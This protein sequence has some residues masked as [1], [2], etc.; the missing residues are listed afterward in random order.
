[1]PYALVAH[2]A[3]LADGLTQPLAGDAL[4]DGS[5]PAAKVGFTYAGSASKGGPADVA[6]G[7][8]CTGCVTVSMLNIDDNIDMQG[9]GLQADTVIAGAFVGD[10]SALTGITMPQGV[11]A[12]GEAVVEIGADG[13]VVCA[14]AVSPEALP[15]DGLDE[16]SNG[17][18]ANQFVDTA[19]SAGA[20]A[21]KDNNPTG[22]ASEIVFPD[23]GIAQKLTVSV[24][25][26]NSDLLGLKVTLFDPDN[27]AYLLWDKGG[28]GASLQATYPEP[29]PTLSGD[30]TTWVGK[31][32]KGAWRLQV[33][34]TAPGAGPTDGA[35]NSWQVAIETLSN[36]KVASKGVFI[37]E[38]GLK[39]QTAD[40]AGQH[41]F[42]CDATS[43]G[44]MY[45]NTADAIVYV[46]DGAAMVPLSGN[47]PGGLPAFA[48]CKALKTARPYAPTGAYLLD[49]DG[50]N[51][52]MQPFEAFCEMDTDGGG[53]TLV[54]KVVALEH[55][56]DGGVLDSNDT[57][58]WKDKQYLGSI[59]DLRYENALGPSY[60]SVPFTDFML[61][62][63]F[64][65]DRK[66][67]WRMDESFDSLFAIF[68]AGTKKTTT[69]LLV[70]TPCNLDYRPSCSCGKGPDATGPQFYGFN[71]NGDGGT[72]GGALFN[73]VNPGG[74]CSVLAGWG[75]SNQTS[76]YAGGGLGARCQ[77]RTH[78]MGRHYWGYGDGCN[79]YGW[80]NTK[81]V[82]TFQPH[83]FFV[84]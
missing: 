76:E 4:Q 83:A 28:P 81:D 52:P 71:I 26:S 35:L 38:G 2:R 66:L 21:I 18:L 45:L 36:A 37:A 16:V 9:F 48:S 32:P 70:G 82:D 47:Q 34:D 60:E 50:A 57:A 1:V 39:L 68:N 41:P 61:M 25:I 23:V 29:T 43:A 65:R 3:L 79:S 30:L 6:L 64:D 80:S 13:A 5:L 67:A 20:V 69:N 19:M 78:Q 44:R 24:D 62:G 49:P 46:C 15:A 72:G 54:G 40:Q 33:I 14:N 12:P 74:W 58:R 63:L 42:A 84:R 77:G 17:L 11:C 75:R 59:T 22:I 27:V 51:G 8:Q 56:D 53:W 10:G 31:N 73:G 7:L 55:D